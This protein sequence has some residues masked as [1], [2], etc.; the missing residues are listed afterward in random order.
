MNTAILSDIT[1]NLM[2]AWY[3][4]LKFLVDLLEEHDIDFDEIINE[5]EANFWKDTAHDFNTIVYEV[6]YKIATDFI[7]KNESL[8]EDESSEFTIYTNYLDS[9]LWF[10]SE[11]VQKK[12]EEDV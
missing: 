7:T 2:G 9:H 1:R 12:F 6:Y 5:V 3:L 11:K 8:F 10:E 4:D